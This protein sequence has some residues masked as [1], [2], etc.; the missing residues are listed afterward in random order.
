MQRIELRLLASGAAAAAAEHALGLGGRV[1][2]DEHVEDHGW[3]RVPEHQLRPRGELLAVGVEAAQPREL[4]RAEHIRAVVEKGGERRGALGGGA[5]VGQLTVGLEVAVTLVAARAPRAARVHRLVRAA[6]ERL[7]VGAGLR[8]L[9]TAAAPP[10]AA[11]AELV[12]VVAQAAKLLVHRA[13]LA[14]DAADF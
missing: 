10:P 1:V 2:E 14:R 11:R 9:C 4:G 8:I 5:G 6:P 12:D 3:L 7:G 13:H